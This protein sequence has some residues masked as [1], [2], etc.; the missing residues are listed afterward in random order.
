MVSR[1][2]GGDEARGKY[3]AATTPTQKTMSLLYYRPESLIEILGLNLEEYEI[4][5][6]LS[7]VNFSVAK[8]KVK[9]FPIL[10]IREKKY[11]AQEFN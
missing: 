6:Y 2:E 5:R 1:F 9:Q 10:H 8:N 11:V 3:D 7:P 4:D